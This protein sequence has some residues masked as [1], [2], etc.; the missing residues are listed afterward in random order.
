MGDR[1]GRVLML[2]LAGTVA[3]LLQ[4]PAHAQTESPWSVYESVQGSFNSAGDLFRIDTS[5]RYRVTDHFEVDGGLPVYVV[6]ASDS[7]GLLGEGWNTGIGNAY[8]DLRLM[9][10]GDAWYLSSAVRTAVPTGDRERGFS[11]GKVSVDWTSSLAVYAPGLTLFGSAG[12]ANTVADTSF[13][14]RPFTSSGVVGHF[15]GGAFVPFTQTVG[16][17]FLG[18]A[19]RG[20]GEQQI[21]SRLVDTD[22]GSIR[23]RRRA[24]ESRVE[25]RGEDLADDHGISL[26][27]DVGTASGV[28]FQAGYTRSVPYAY[29]TAFFSVGFDIVSLVR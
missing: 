28:N 9:A 25:T 12:V 26:W 24:F 11:T 20:G 5:V 22:T 17:G 1:V 14:V 6:R 4:P 29:D 8:V 13:F 19:V 21:I 3:L 16:L 10:T 15:D 27:F 2:F 18:Y 7:P 23:D